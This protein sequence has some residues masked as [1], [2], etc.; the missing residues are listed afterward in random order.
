MSPN[1]AHQEDSPQTF[2]DA[3]LNRIAPQVNVA[4]FVSFAPDLSQRFSWV[5]GRSP[6]TLFCS[7]EEACEALLASAESR[8]INI[9]S[10]KPGATKGNKLAENIGSAGEAVSAIAQRASNGFFTIANE[11]IPIDDGGVSGVATGGVIEFAPGDTPKCVDKPEV[12]SLPL[13]DGSRL[14]E[15]VYGFPPEISFGDDQRIEF[16]L[17]PLPRGYLRQHTIIWELEASSPVR[18]VQIGKWPNRFSKFLGDKAYGLL[19]AHLLGFSVPRTIVISRGVAP[20]SFGEHTGTSEPWLRTCPRVPVAGKY[21]TV[22]GW[23][24][25]FSLMAQCDPD[26]EVLASILAQE[27]VRFLWSG[28]AQTTDHGP[29]VEGARGRGDPFMLA[30]TPKETIPA[31]VHQ[32]VAETHEALVSHLRSVKFEWVW[33]SERVWLV[34]LHHRRKGLTED[35]IYPGEASEHRVFDPRLFDREEVLERLRDLVSEIAGKNIGIVV[36][37]NVGVT[38]HVGDIL[39]EARIPSRLKWWDGED[40]T[41]L[42]FELETTSP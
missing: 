13:K 9:R 1:N 22:Y 2:K 24:D 41:Q 37:G 25:P 32:R 6:N 38:S 11:L 4:Q 17:H 19:I 20:F 23:Q 12:A 8:K 40:A 31:M 28:A 34:Q 29:Y 30:A 36:L 7:P 14:L 26:A 15:I 3:V 27:S 16:S 35:V 5:Y 39:A 10:F 18:R 33:D 42:S 21:P